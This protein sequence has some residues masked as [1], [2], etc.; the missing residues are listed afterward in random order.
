MDIGFFTMP[1]HPIDKDYKNNFNVNGNTNVC[2]GVYK[3][4]FSK[5]KDKPE[6]G[7]RVRQEVRLG[8]LW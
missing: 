6:K 8:A 5:K 2:E 1:I 4:Y 7:V 3:K